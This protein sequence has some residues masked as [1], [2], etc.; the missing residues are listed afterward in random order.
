MQHAVCEG[1]E[2]QYLRSW[3]SLVQEKAQDSG[4]TLNPRGQVRR[5]LSLAGPCSHVLVMRCL[6]IHSSLGFQQRREGVP[7]LSKPCPPKVAVQTRNNDLLVILISG[8]AAEVHQVW[9]EL[10]LID[11]NNL[12]QGIT[13]DSDP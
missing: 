3:S 2:V 5:K 4:E 10:G 6:Y 13:A 1:N 9:K 11:G 12:G 7:R 8:C